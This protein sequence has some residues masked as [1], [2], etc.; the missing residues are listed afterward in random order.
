MPSSSWTD[1]LKQPSSPAPWMPPLQQVV[2]HPKVAMLPLGT[3]VRFSHYLQRTWRGSIKVWDPRP[4]GGTESD[5][6]DYSVVF[7]QPLG[8]EQTKGYPWVDG[9]VVGHRT[10]SDGKREWDSYGEDGTNYYFTATE[11][12]RAYLIAWNV[13]RAIARVKIEH[14]EALEDVL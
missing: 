7:S 12:Y 4:V 2:T 11:S 9:I 14:V 13:N 1:L 10:L 3:P 5:P 8:W 6:N